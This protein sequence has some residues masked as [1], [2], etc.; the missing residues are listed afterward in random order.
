M[1]ELV[2]FARDHSMVEVVLV[3]VDLVSLRDSKVLPYMQEHGV[4][5]VT[6]LQLDHPDPASALR[7]VVPDWPDSVP[8]TLVLDQTGRRVG[9]YTVAVTAETLAAAI[10]PL[11]Q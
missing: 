3:N 7:A 2:E 8:T 6:A 5:G 10:K 1:P 11:S 9:L 4:S